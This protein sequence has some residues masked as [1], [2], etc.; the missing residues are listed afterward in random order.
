LNFSFYTL[1]YQTHLNSL[2]DNFEEDEAM[3]LLV[4]GDFNKV[5]KLEFDLLKF[6]GLKRDHAILDVGCGS[7]RL[8]YF[9]KDFLSGRYVGFD[10]LQEPLDYAKTK[11]SRSDWEF[12][13]HDGRSLSL[14]PSSFDFI[15]FFSVF[16]HIQDEDMFFYLQES[17][18]A[19]KAD[20][21]IIFSFLDFECESHWV[22]FENSLKDRNE[23]HVMNRFLSKSTIEIWTK[24][25]NLKIDAIYDGNTSFIPVLDSGANNRKQSDISRTAFG[26]SVAILSKY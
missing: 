20:G 22:Y 19:L 21:K 15:T 16:T 24:K 4:G 9:L 14:V 17:S 26:Q 2:L 8:A 6:Q 5:G 23:N 3:S 10:I 12:K 13:L 25:L 1:P 11:C 18:I 7:G